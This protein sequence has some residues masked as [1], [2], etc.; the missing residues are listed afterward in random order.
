M[1]EATGGWHEYETLE[2]LLAAQSDA[3]EL[4]EAAVVDRQRE[5]TWGTYFIRPS[6]THPPIWGYVM[7]PEEIVDELMNM[8]PTSSISEVEYEVTTIQVAYER[9]LRYAHHFSA[10]TP[11]GEWG[12]SHIATLWPVSQEVYEEAKANG[13]YLSQETA[14]AVAK[15]IED[16]RPS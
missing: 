9:G 6:E 16:H 11:N 13:W 4:A 3:L 14:D 5:I 12:S 8:T 2:E 1:P 15:D 10:L 7:T